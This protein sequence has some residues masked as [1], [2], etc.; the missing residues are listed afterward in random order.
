MLGD[1]RRERL[2]HEKYSGLPLWS[3]LRGTAQVGSLQARFKDSDSL[4][5][6]IGHEGVFAAARI[7]GSCIELIRAAGLG[8]R[9]DTKITRREK[10]Q[11]QFQVD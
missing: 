11:R 5:L 10:A 4:P 2:E 3:Q 9:L 6:T 7:I 8:D 1:P